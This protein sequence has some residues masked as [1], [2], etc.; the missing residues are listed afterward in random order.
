MKRIIILALVVMLLLVPNAF[1]LKRSYEH[2]TVKQVRQMMED[3]E[4]FVI[5]DARPEEYYEATHIPGAINIPLTVLGNDETYE[6]LPDLR[7]TIIVY[8]YTGYRSREAAS[9]L[10]HMGY[11]QVREFGG[12]D[13]WTG[14]TVGTEEVEEYDD[15]PFEANEYANPDDFYYE[16]E[17][18]FDDYDEAEEYYY[19]HVGW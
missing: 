6:L 3:S 11:T 2:L 16:F 7:Q 9:T 17:D 13:L 15:D 10:G 8:C 14:K 18:E 1:A 4:E 19:E 12:L 5:V